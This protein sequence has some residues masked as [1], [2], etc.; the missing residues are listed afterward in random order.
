[1]TFN[2]PSDSRVAAKALRENWPMAPE[3]R[4]AAIEHLRA[5]IA[6]PSTRP[7]LLGVARKALASVEPQ[8]AIQ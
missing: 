2:S 1:M 7:Q 4:Q 5:V 8:E 3:Q 6:D